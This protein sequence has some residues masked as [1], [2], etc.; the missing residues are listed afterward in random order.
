[1][2]YIYLFSFFKIDNC[3]N[4]HFDTVLLKEHGN[5]WTKV[6]KCDEIFSEVA[7]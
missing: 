2:K 4:L 5:E 6:S 3:K 7:H 1:M